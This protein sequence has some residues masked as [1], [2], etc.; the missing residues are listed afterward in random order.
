MRDIIQGHQYLLFLTFDHHRSFISKE[1]SRTDGKKFVTPFLRM[2]RSKG[3]A[4]GMMRALN[5][6]IYV[7]W[8]SVAHLNTIKGTLK[9][10][11]KSN[12]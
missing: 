9:E 3:A 7:S 10:K 11:C 12:W 2:T 5:A 4:A 1:K 6:R 8:G